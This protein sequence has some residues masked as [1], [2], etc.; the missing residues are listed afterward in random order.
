MIQKHRV[1]LVGGGGYVGVELQR[2][3]AESNYYVR[4]L[5]TFWYPNGKWSI[6]DGDFVNKIE[7]LDGD[8][9]DKNIAVSYTHLTLPTKA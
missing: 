5:D 4:V 3:L 2:S 1:L 7:Y 9:R 6:S 8:I